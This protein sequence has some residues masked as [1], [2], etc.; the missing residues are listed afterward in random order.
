MFHIL[1]LSHLLRYPL[2]KYG[3]GDWPTVW[4]SSVAGNRILQSSVIKKKM[5]F[6]SYIRKFRWERL[7]SHIWGRGL[8]NIWGNEQISNHTYM[9]KTYSHIWLG[10]CFLLNFLIYEKD[11]IYFLS[12]YSTHKGFYA[13]REIDYYHLQYKAS[14]ISIP[15]LRLYF[16]QV[17]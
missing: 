8:P 6:S 14:R 13:M 3:N 4:N 9:R 7:Q 12:L 17:G 1:I 15:A 5:K 2:I 10:N 16:T 11:F